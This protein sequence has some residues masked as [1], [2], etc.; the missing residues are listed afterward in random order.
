MLWRVSGLGLHFGL[1]LDS[2][3]NESSIVEAITNTVFLHFALL[4]P[5]LYYQTYLQPSI[6][7]KGLSR[8][9]G[10]SNIHWPEKPKAQKAGAAQAGQAVLR[11]PPFRYRNTVK[12]LSTMLLVSIICPFANQFDTILQFKLCRISIVLPLKIP[13]SLKTPTQAFDRTTLKRTRPRGCAGAMIL[14]QQPWH[15][16]LRDHRCRETQAV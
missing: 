1:R 11:N 6:G 7:C 5:W 10:F 13:K 16:G 4:Y 12:E 14:V 3:S 9:T 2:W 8:P 15:S